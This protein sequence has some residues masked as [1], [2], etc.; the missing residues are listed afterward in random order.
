[1]VD[2]EKGTPTWGI[3]QL[4]TTHSS[5][6]SPDNT[7]PVVAELRRTG[8]TQHGMTA[9]QRLRLALD[10]K[11]LCYQEQS[12]ADWRADILRISGLS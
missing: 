8:P 12:N 3:S 6:F 11:C 2:Y 9:E 10:Q 5:G 7:C 4:L 1:M